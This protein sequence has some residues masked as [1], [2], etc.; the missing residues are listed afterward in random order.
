[1]RSRSLLYPLSLALALS[2]VLSLTFPAFAA[3]KPAS[4]DVQILAINDF[5]GALNPSSGIGGAAFLA[6]YIKNLSAQNPNTVRVSAGDNIGASPI[7]SALFH[8]QPTIQALSMM[9]F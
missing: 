8:D 3:T 2:L 7:Q 9:G 6:T 4:V 1:M 5:H